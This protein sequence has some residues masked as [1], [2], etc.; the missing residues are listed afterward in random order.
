[1]WWSRLHASPAAMLFYVVFSQCVCMCVCV[2]I[3]MNVFALL[4]LRSSCLWL[5][6]LCVGGDVSRPCVWGSPCECV[7][8]AEVWLYMK[9]HVYRYMMGSTCSF[10]CHNCVKGCRFVS[11][12]TYVFAASV[13]VC[14][15]NVNRQ[16]VGSVTPEFLT[17]K[18][19]TKF[20]LFKKNH[21]WSACPISKSFLK[22]DRKSSLLTNNNPS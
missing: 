13:F 2:V 11:A 1:M 22:F 19:L 6:P 3:M 10:M 14:A 4:G 20:T 16:T 17:F 9:R 8:M 5:T 15:L 12:W 7:C 18:F 21:C